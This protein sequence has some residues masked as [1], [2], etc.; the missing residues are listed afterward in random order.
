MD[1][2]IKILFAAFSQVKGFLARFSFGFGIFGTHRVSGEYDEGIFRA[3]DCLTEA[4][5]TGA[6][7]SMLRGLLRIQ[8]FRSV[9]PR[10]CDSRAPIF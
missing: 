4:V 2:L 6:K 10:F 8:C 5:S 1:D 7:T 3:V 9:R